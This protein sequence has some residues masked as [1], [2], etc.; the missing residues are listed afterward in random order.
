M[1]TKDITKIV[2]SKHSSDKKSDKK[3]EKKDDKIEENI[4]PWIEKYRPQSL[5]R[6]MGHVEI[7]D[8]LNKMIEK[9]KL[10]HMLFFGPSGT[11]KTSTIK[12]LAKKYYGAQYNFMV[13]ELNASASRGIDVIRDSVKKF[14]NTKNVLH[15]SIVQLQGNDNIVKLVILDE[16]DAMTTDAQDSLRIIMQKYIKNARFC[17]ICNYIAQ[18]RKAVRSRCVRLKFTPIKHDDMKQ[19]VIDICEN[20]NIKIDNTGIETLIY[21]ANGDMRTI[22]NNLQS[23]PKTNKT[24]TSVDVNENLGFPTQDQINEI[25]KI[26]RSCGLEDAVDKIKVIVRKNG[27]S[28]NDLL[29]ELHLLLLK[30]KSIKLRDKFIILDNMAAVEVSQSSNSNEKIQ[31]TALISCFSLV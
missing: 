16:T 3:D 31:L 21:R 17:L 13:L 11:G 19:K 9:K 30:D 4:L 24:L 1:A 8:T 10:S 23:M 27:L 7:I 2:K 26:I 29:T 18:I 28:V 25:Y 20:E 12:A 22:L 15:N 6:I 5:D 14:V